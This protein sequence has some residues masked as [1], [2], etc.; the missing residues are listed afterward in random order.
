MAKPFRCWRCGGVTVRL[1]HSRLLTK[2]KCPVL[3]DA[4]V[5]IW[6]A[7]GKTPSFSD[8]AAIIHYYTHATE[9]G[10]EH[11]FSRYRSMDRDDPALLAVVAEL[12]EDASGKHAK[13]QV[14][15]I[16]DDVE[17]EIEEYDGI[18]HI[19]EAHRTWS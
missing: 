14:V 15:E 17:W 4:Y 2:F 11:Y 5:R 1:S 6:T 18:E 7:S 16:P 13:L 9:R 3:D 19:A 8:P 10:D 12:G